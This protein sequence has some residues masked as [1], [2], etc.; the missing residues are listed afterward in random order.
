MNKYIAT[1]LIALTQAAV[2]DGPCPT[3]VNSNLSLQEFE[4]S[5]FA[6]LWFEYVWEKGFDDGLDYKCSM[7]TWL[8]DTDK[9]VAFNHVHYAEDDG[10]FAQ[11]DL[12]WTSKT[13]H[14]YQPQSLVYN[15]A[16]AQGNETAQE[17]QM[18]FVFTDYYSHLIGESCVPLE[19]NRH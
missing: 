8:T 2:S 19:G 10:K 11:L 5:P 15:R 7:W 9:M 6:G 14:G 12:N 17:R 1:G 16:K 18:N 13:D 4:S 3:V